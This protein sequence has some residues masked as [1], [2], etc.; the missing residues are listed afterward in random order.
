M[1]IHEQ[2][3]T[4]FSIPVANLSR[5]IDFYNTVF[6]STLE[7]TDYQGMAMA[8]FPMTDG[9]PGGALGQEADFTPLAHPS[10][11]LNGG[12]DLQQ[13]LDRVPGAGGE[14]LVPKTDIGQGWGFFAHLK[15]SEGNVLGVWSPR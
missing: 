1:N 11:Y 10:I 15:D 5:A 12:D 3:I 2:P 13:C 9:Q 7:A 8:F 4:W 14:V 6:G